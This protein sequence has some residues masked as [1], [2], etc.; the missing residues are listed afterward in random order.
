MI[1]EVALNKGLVE[2]F[3]RKHIGK[4]GMRV[5]N[6]FE[7]TK[8]PVKDEELAA[9]SK[10]KVT[11]IRAILNK[12]HY[13]GFVEYNKRKDANSGWY[14]YTWQLNKKRIFEAL[15]TE[16]IEELEKLKKKQE[17]NENYSVFICKKGCIEMPFE[18][19]AEYNFKCPN[20]G[21]SMS[22]FDTIKQTKQI[23]K[24]IENLER[25]INEIKEVL[26]YKKVKTNKKKTQKIGR[27]SKS[28]SKQKKAKKR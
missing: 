9:G 27:I 21:D 14:H 17:L 12:L 5:V 19:A 10:L 26:S 25:Q 11:E 6:V 24:T 8:K 28:S 22:F 23:N 16:Q 3:I 1:E 15:L 7:K 2:E 13:K 20:C 18:V 4:N